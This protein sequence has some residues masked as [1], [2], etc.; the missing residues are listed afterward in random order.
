MINYS[1]QNFGIVI[2]R[3]A[4]DLPDGIEDLFDEASE[5]LQGYSLRQGK[6]GLTPVQAGVERYPALAAA[7]VNLGILKVAD[8]VFG[9]NGYLFYGSDLSAFSTS[10]NWH[11]DSYSDIIT[12]KIA[13]YLSGSYDTDQNFLY[14]PGSHHVDDQYSRSLGRACKW[15]LS[16]GM[17]LD[18]LRCSVDING[19]EGEDAML[20][21]AQFRIRR[22]DVIVFDN[23]GLHAVQ[24]NSLRRLIALGFVPSAE[25][26]SWVSEGC[27]S[28]PAHY[29]REL[30]RFQCA[31]KIIE[32]GRSYAPHYA[33]AKITGLPDALMQCLAFKDYSEEDIDSNCHS[34][35]GNSKAAAW[36]TLNKHAVGFP[37]W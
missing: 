4:L 26:I 11:R 21:A 31:R 19:N 18:H 36:M 5:N 25:S 32:S 34:L 2:V 20:A 30:V 22:G 3:G 24:S 15:P 9:K 14:V 28:S 35:L 33:H 23:R 1:L 37:Q 13:I 8:M 12:W 17:T 6:R 29:Y 16:S 7:L 10:S 27:F